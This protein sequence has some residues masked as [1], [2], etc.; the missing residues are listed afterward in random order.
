MATI[1][2]SP[3]ARFAV[4]RFRLTLDCAIDGRT[5]YPIRQRSLPQIFANSGVI[6]ADYA[7]SI[8]G[9]PPLLSKR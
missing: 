1:E 3:S 2:K 9:R 5:P 8:T 7:R 6:V 4:E